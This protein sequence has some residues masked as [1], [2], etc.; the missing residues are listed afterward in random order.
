MDRY[1]EGTSMTTTPA[2]KPPAVSAAKKYR[3]QIADLV[4]GFSL[5][6]LE[7]GELAL[8]VAGLLDDALASAQESAPSSES[9]DNAEFRKK[10]YAQAVYDVL[11]AEF[12]GAS[13]WKV[14]AA[15]GRIVAALDRRATT[16][17]TAQVFR[18]EDGR[19][20]TKVDGEY[21]SDSIGSGLFRRVDSNAGTDVPGGML[22]VRR[23]V[24]EAF[25][26]CLVYGSNMTPT[27]IADKLLASN[28][29]AVPEIGR[30]EDWGVRMDDGKQSGWVKDIYGFIYLCSKDNAER[31]CINDNY[32]AHRVRL[33]AYDLGAPFNSQAS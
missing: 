22:A 9:I 32:K 6:P 21:Y 19:E 3:S 10:V 16:G 27:E 20:I 12:S 7:R 17:T 5:A 30:T 2:S 26:E 15:T 11:S 25:S 13:Q 18:S 4:Q 29:S 8:A 31:M 14:M 23:A 1:A 33:V 28:A 24:F